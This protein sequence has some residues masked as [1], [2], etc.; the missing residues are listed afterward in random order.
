MLIDGEDEHGLGRGIDE[1]EQVPLARLKHSAEL[2]PIYHVRATIHVRTILRYSS[3]QFFRLT[4]EF[5]AARNL[6][7]RVLGRVASAAAERVLILN[8]RVRSHAYLKVGFLL[9]SL[10]T[11][12]LNVF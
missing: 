4:A 6:A 10:L 1:L 8:E 11:E 5:R 12:H 7:L 3:A 2:R 9:V